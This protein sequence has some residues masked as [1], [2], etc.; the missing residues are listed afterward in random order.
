MFEYLVVSG[1]GTNGFMHVG[2]LSFIERWVSSEYG[3]SMTEYFTGFAGTSIGALLCLCIVCGLRTEDIMLLCTTFSSHVLTCDFS[4]VML[5]EINA[6]RENTLLRECVQEIFIRTFG[7]PDMTFAELFSLTRRDFVVCAC[8]LLTNQVDFF[9]AAATP[10]VSITEAV[11]ASMALPFVYPPIKINGSVYVDGGC[12][13]NLPL[14]VFPI[15]RTLALW[16]REAKAD[17]IHTDLSLA[18]LTKQLFRS[19]VAAQDIV[20]YECYKKNAKNFINLQAI[21][22]GFLPMPIRNNTLPIQY[23]YLETGQHF[24]R[25]SQNKVSALFWLVT[26]QLFLYIIRQFNLWC[27]AQYV[28]ST[29]LGT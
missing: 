23:G 21:S 29:S 28:R 12:Q 15:E 13:L 11:L 1:G 5:C 20:L 27:L 22:T 10:G 9:S 6:L 17:V 2:A 7:R 3:T 19:F 14:C 24:L 16:I 18:T 26:D 4:L 25:Y 8:N